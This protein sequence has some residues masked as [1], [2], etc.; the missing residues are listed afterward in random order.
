MRSAP[1]PASAISKKSSRTEFS[2]DLGQEPS[3]VTDLYRVA[4]LQPQ[5]GIPGGAKIV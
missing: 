1:A 4:H 5:P 2:Q 3:F